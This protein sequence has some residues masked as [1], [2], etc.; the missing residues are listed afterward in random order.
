MGMDFVALMRYSRA[1]GVVPAIN[2]L[3]N[4]TTPLSAEVRSLW[5]VSG[6]F[7]FDW[8]RA[9]WVAHDNGRQVRR[10]R[11]PDLTVAL[12]TVDGFVLTFGRGVCCTYHLLRWRLFLTD[13]RWQA[14]MLGA[15]EGL[16]GLVRSP[17]VALMSDFHPSY[18]AFFAGAGFDA[19][20]RAA[21]GRE[22]EAAE[23]AELYE[24][25]EP[26]IWDSHGFW[27]LRSSEQR[28]AEPAVA[29]DPRRG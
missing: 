29:P 19:C 6:Y 2:G 8:G 25:P 4:R 3:E 5:R 21:V 24:E 17:D 16:A 23:I 11:G 9:N 26:H 15:C 28:Q 20:L 27:R 10:P 1:R 12:R 18:L 13:P 22:A 7:G 14:A